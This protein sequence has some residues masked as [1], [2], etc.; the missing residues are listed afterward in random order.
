V[1]DDLLLRT[2]REL[3]LAAVTGAGSNDTPSWV[4]DRVTAL[5]DEEEVEAGRRIFAA[6]DPIEFIYFMREGRLRLSAEGLPSWTYDGRWVIGP[7]DALL[8]RPYRRTAVALTDLNLLKIRAGDW[9]ELLEDSSELVRSAIT[10]AARG[11]GVLEARLWATQAEPHGFVVAPVPKAARA[12]S[13]VDRLATLADIQML[14]SGGV[15]VL[16]DLVGM[17][18]ERAFASG[19]LLWRRGDAP[20]WAFLVLSGQVLATR[21]DPTL[22]VRFGPGSFVVGAGALGE[23]AGAWEPRA[24]VDT[25]VLAIRLEDWFDLMEEHFDLA[26]SALGGFALRR[27]ELLNQL[28]AGANEILLT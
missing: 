8:D 17:T 22:E 2:S 11:I 21:S 18:E 13:F 9:I 25:R 1:P 23:F 26:R 7:A 19:D 27:E 6:G 28:A 5:L 10:N 4:I 24:L 16:A 20:G 15:Q 14:R 12:M 3:F